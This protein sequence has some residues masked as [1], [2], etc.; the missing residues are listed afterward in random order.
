MVECKKEGKVMYREHR[1]VLKLIE[2]QLLQKNTENNLDSL[3]EF[4]C[5]RLAECQKHRTK[6][7]SYLS[8]PLIFYL[9]AKKCRFKNKNVRKRNKQSIGIVSS[10]QLR[11]IFPLLNHI[12]PQ[13]WYFYLFV[14]FGSDFVSWIF[15][16]KFITS[17]RWKIFSMG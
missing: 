15:I 1:E 10:K 8:S 16:K 9:L 11:I 7:F 5:N 6:I 13:G 14:L 17:W 4:S 3:K 12:W 2:C